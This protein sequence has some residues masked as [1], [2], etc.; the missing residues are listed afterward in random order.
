MNCVRSIVMCVYVCL[1]ARTSQKLPDRISRNF[2]CLLP[3][4]LARSL[5]GGVAICRVLPVF[6]MTSPWHVIARHRRPRK[7]RVLN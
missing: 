6:S 2:R 7:R 5:S 4:A 3:A 1:S